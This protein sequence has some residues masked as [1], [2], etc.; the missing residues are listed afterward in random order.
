MTQGSKGDDFH[1]WKESGF[2]FP[3]TGFFL[4]IDG[5]IAGV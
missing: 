1:S 5:I 3:R 4:D 2:H